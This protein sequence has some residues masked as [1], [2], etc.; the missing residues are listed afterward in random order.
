VWRKP[1][2]DD[3]PDALYHYCSLDTFREIIESR[4]IRLSDIFEMKDRSEVMHV[5]ELLPSRLRRNY[6]ETYVGHSPFRSYRGKDGADILDQLVS[7]IRNQIEAVKS[8]MYIACF[9]ICG[10]DIG[11]WTEYADDGC[12]IAIAFD[13]AALHD[14]TQ[15]AHLQL[16]D[17]C[18]CVAEHEA[19]VDRA[20][21]PLI[22]RALESAANNSNVATRNCTYEYYGTGRGDTQYI[23]YPHRGRTI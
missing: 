1:N 21:V 19:F 6:E 10:D 16:T 2:R 9:S 20:I 3:V 14:I 17:V 5:L 7:D 15:C 8:L 13:G 11:Q 12:G 22:F 4:A 23:S 18:Y